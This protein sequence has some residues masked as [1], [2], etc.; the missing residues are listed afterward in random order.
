M[1]VTGSGKTTVGTLLARKLGWSFADADDFHSEENK[2]KMAHGI[3]LTDADRAPWLAALRQAIE[4]WESETKNVVLACSALKRSYRNQLRTP[5]EQKSEAVRFVY[6]KGDYDLICSRLR[7]R[8]GHF[9]TE[10]IL[11]RQFTDLE[12]PED[13]VTISINITPEQIVAEIARNLKV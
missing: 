1:G 6:L 2:T 7:A 8:H 12:D 11:K 9:A 10:S 4:N 3:P 13:A 5:E